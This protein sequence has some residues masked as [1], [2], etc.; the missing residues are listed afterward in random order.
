MHDVKKWRIRMEATTNHSGENAENLHVKDNSIDQLYE[1]REKLSGELAAVNR[2]IA[3][4][5]AKESLRQEH[6]V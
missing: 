4:L 1:L 2:T 6:D 3:L 5:E